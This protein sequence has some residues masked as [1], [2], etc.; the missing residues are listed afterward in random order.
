MPGLDGLAGGGGVG[1]AVL[2]LGVDPEVVV[3]VDHQVP[4]PG[5]AGRD[6]G[7]DLG[8]LSPGLGVGLL[9]DVVGDGAAAVVPGGHPVEGQGL[10][11]KVGGL[12]V[13]RGSRPGWREI[14]NMVSKA[15][16]WRKLERGH[17]D[18]RQSSR[19]KVS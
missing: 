6:V 5:V 18:L 4:H 9:D 7:G 8:P 12:D 3:G 10:A 14:R 19:I 1:D 2:V 11:G 16:I 13:P 17:F 15:T